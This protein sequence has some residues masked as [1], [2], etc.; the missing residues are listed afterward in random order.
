MLIVIS[1]AKKLDETPYALPDGL[2]LTDPEFSKDALKLAGIARK[3]T[4]DEL[5]NLSGISENLARLNKDRFAAFSA[6][7]NAGT[8]FP[9]IHCFAGDTYIGLQARTMPSTTLHWASRRL[10][11]LSGLYG[12]LR[13]LD[14]IQAYRLEMGS[15]LANPKGP[16]L[17]AFWGGRLAKSIN[18][19][20]QEQSAKVIVNCAS[21]E[22]FGALDR[23]CLKP[24]VITPIFMEETDGG[25]K[26]VSFWAKRARGAMARFICDNEL[27]SPADLLA[28][29][30][31]GYRFRS[32]L[33]GEEKLVF[34]RPV[35]VEAAA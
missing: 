32:D 8:V 19:L 11:I 15:R 22:Y 13:P 23:N 3:L 12:L 29:S 33:S 35:S 27:T 5:R 31:L 30:H 7:P 9:A 20:A 34:S 1:P 10:R 25:L 28:F 24:R 17:Y 26:T 21:V 2:T 6:T 16:D 14:A 18:L 4:V